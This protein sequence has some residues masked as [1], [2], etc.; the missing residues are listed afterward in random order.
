M[1]AS[2]E[3]L[4]KHG[5]P[6]SIYDLHAHNCLNH[7]DNRLSTWHLKEKG[8][9]IHLTVTGNLKTNSSLVLAKYAEDGIGIAYLPH[10][11][12]TAALREKRLIPILK[13]AWPD[14]LPIY[15]VYPQRQ[16]VNKK[17]AV[18]I[19]AFSQFFEKSE[20]ILTTY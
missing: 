4:K 10:F 14:P 15:A 19:E 11:S 17:L 7:H 12:M 9:N 8:K 16:E 2:P 3:Y 6:E 1:C 13:G 18:V 20:S 5:E